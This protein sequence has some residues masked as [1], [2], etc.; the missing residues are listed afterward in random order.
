MA[1]G[2]LRRAWSAY[3]LRWKRR[4]LLWRAMRAGRALTPLADRTGAIRPRDILLFAT[5]RNEIARLPEFLAHYRALGVAHFL[6]VDNDSDDGTPGYLRG[7]ADL[8]L[9]RASGSYRAARF[10]MDW[11]GA[12]LIRHGHGHWCVTVDAD[13]LL[14]YPGCARHDLPALTAHLGARGIAGMGALMLDLYPAGRLGQADAPPDAPLTD[15]LPFF[16]AGPYRSRV[17]SPRRN[18]WVQGGVRERAFFADRPDRAPTLNKLPLIRWHRRMTYVNSTH[19]MLPPRM[20]DLYDG[21]GDPRLSGV[22][23]HGKFLPEIVARS[24]EE[25]LR[26]QHFADPD[27]YAGYHRALT[28]GPVLRDAASRRYEGP[29]LLVSLGLMG[30]AG[31]PPQDTSG[32]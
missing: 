21:P 27:A 26:R 28:A 19:S 24:H 29:D 10:G 22:L 3:R 23:L 20:N 9:W 14:V 17:M 12:L 8:S 13:E 18:R 11:L 7:Q 5:L 1:D 25:L 31:W 6:I 32:A 2:R 4:E 16:D 15:R 30:S